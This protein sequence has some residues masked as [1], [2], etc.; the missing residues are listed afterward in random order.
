M[1]DDHTSLDVLVLCGGKGTRIESILSDRPKVLAPIGR[2]TYLDYLFGTL[3]RAGFRRVILATG[4]MAEQVE[5]HVKKSGWGKRDDI[6]IIFSKEE[7][8][9]GTGGA[10]KNAEPHI[11]SDHFMVLNGDTLFT[12]DFGKFHAFHQEKGGKLTL[13][14]ARQRGEDFA[15]VI[16]DGDNRILEYREKEPIAQEGYASAGLYIMGRALLDLMQEGAFSL[17]YDFLPRVLDDSY[18]FAEKVEFLDI[19]TPERY[20]EADTYS[21][22]E[23]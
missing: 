1:T 15:R 5:E 17:E 9:L 19:G 22:D 6:E 8:P 12:V 3:V 18:G 23:K 7:E 10:V 2:W 21:N 4:Y 20:R 14:L 16:V 13:A 11:R